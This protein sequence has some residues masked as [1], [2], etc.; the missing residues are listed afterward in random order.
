M[1]LDCLQTRFVIQVAKREL[2]RAEEE[3]VGNLL[4]PWLS[5]LLG[6][7]C[8]HQQENL[9]LVIGLQESL[10]SPVMY[11]SGQYLRFKKITYTVNA[12]VVTCRKRVDLIHR[13]SWDMSLG[14][15]CHRLISFS[16]R[17]L[18]H[19][20]SLWISGE[21][22]RANRVL[23]HSANDFFKG[24]GSRSSDKKDLSFALSIFH[25]VHGR[26]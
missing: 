24:Q 23:H 12:C 18:R 14:P 22:A 3:L 21:G 15:K 2:L 8:Q 17:S 7:Y 26:R 25:K 11:L 5:S 1:G 16:R 19:R 6:A 10:R 13:K 4:I 9:I 20:A